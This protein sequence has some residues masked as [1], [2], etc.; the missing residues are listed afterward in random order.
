MTLPDR[1]RQHLSLHGPDT[2]SGIAVALD[3]KE[4]AVNQ[5]TRN[6]VA[7]KALLVEKVPGIRGMRSQ[8]TLVQVETP[9]SLDANEEKIRTALNDLQRAWG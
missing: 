3:A 8:F 9:E 6:L 1:I 5:A 4:K 7:D 2:I